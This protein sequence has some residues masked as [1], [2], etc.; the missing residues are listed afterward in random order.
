MARYVIV[1]IVE[2][3]GEWHA[4]PILLRRWLAFRR[5]HNVDVDV[6]GPVRAAGKGA[7]KVAHDGE[8]ELGVEHYVQIALLRQPNAV[9]VLVD[10][11][12]D[13]PAILGRDLLK[14]AS[15]VQN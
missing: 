4:V 15:S 10:A 6:A 5:Y 8:N 2:G 7:L 11:D 12:E 1:P 14:R 3:H 9:L 13:C